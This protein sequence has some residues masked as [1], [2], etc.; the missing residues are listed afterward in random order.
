MAMPA[1]EEVRTDDSARSKSAPNSDFPGMHLEL[2]YF[3]WIDIVPNSILLVYI[4]IH[5]K[6]G[7]IA[8]DDLLGE[9]WVNFQLLQNSI[10]EHTA[11]SM[12]VY[13]QFLGQLNF[14]LQTQVPTQ[15][16]LS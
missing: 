15:N 4:S 6:M 1:L 14:I 13:L 2:M 10:S 9:I 12:V 5:P 8:K 16:S 7:L 3:A 11:L